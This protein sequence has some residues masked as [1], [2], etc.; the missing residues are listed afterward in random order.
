MVIR[1]SDHGKGRFFLQ[2]GF[3]ETFE[4]ADRH[5]SVLLLLNRQTT[6][7]GVGQTDGKL[8]HAGR[9]LVRMEIIVTSQRIVKKRVY[10]RSLL[11]MQFQIFSQFGEISHCDAPEN[12]RCAEENP[13]G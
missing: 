4:K 3:P 9:R 6:K 13:G 12:K 8:Q 10:W 1:K 5:D 11:R 7:P 2:I